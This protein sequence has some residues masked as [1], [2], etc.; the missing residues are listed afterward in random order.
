[1][2][3]HELYC[4]KIL[5]ATVDKGTSVCQNPIHLVENKLVGNMMLDLSLSFFCTSPSEP[6]VVLLG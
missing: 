2:S 4:V 5:W 6:S 3:M 1:M